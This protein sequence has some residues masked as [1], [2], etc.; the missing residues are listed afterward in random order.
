MK[1][2]AL[3]IA[4]V[5][6]IATF[7]PEA[8]A[9]PTFAR[10]V[11]MAC[12]ACHY[13]HHPMLNSF[14]RAFKSGAYTLMGAQTL[15]EGEGLS[16]PDRLNMS[17][18]AT[19]G[20]E[21]ESVAT[22][23]TTTNTNKIFT[24]GTGGEFS[25]FMGGRGSDFMGFIAEAGLGGGGLTTTTSTGTV[26][27]TT[28]NAATPVTTTSTNPAPGIIAGTKILMLFPV[29]DNRIGLSIHSSQGQGVAYSF[30][31]LNTGAAATH[32][33]MGT[34]GPSKQHLNA[35]SAAQYLMTDT[36]ATG[37]S[38]VA[39]NTN[40]FINIGAWEAAGND[41]VTGAK[42]LTLNYVR[43]VY[44]MDL[45]GFDTSFGIQHWGGS[46]TELAALGAAG[47]ADAN[48]IDFQAQ[49]DGLGIYASYGT[50]PASGTSGALVDENMFNPS[51]T[52]D[53]KTSFN[54]AATYE[55]AKGATVQGAYR[56]GKQQGQADN[57]IMIG[58][59]YDLAQN[60]SVSLNYTAQS[61]SY[62]DNLATTGGDAGKTATTLLLETLF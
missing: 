1:K 31:T 50:A 34:A 56:N 46:S 35:T 32:K 36:P 44:T 10:Q 3:T 43:G 2:L 20:V 51:S 62:W 58:A 22:G 7:A 57:A 8:S 27:T 25:L 48:V 37:V 41:V 14:G 12:S 30:E 47:K 38:F 55:V 11:G 19:T 21:N 39:N 40:G 16:I 33:M 60:I 23:A 45:A 42:S 49:G 18:Y 53:A 54:I 13:Q 17:V 9:L 6:A 61:G 15:I 29:G 52:T 4:S 5:A 59:T 26:D 24:P 28:P